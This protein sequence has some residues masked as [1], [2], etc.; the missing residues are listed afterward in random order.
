[1]AL[2]QKYSLGHIRVRSAEIV[3]GR[4]PRLPDL[5]ELKNYV[6]FRFG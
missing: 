2:E 3:G 1:M 6:P 4:N 5:Q